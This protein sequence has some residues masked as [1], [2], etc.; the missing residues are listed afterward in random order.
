MLVAA[1]IELISSMSTCSNR[2]SNYFT[3]STLHG[4]RRVR[5]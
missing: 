4:A 3:T 2:E 1:M 5:F